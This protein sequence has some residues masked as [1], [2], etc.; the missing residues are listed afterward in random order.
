[1][2]I[3]GQENVKLF[4]TLP[5]HIII[6]MLLTYEMNATYICLHKD[7]YIYIYIYKIKEYIKLYCAIFERAIPISRVFRRN[8]L[9]LSIFRVPE[10]NAVSF[11]Q[12]TLNLTATGFQALG[13]YLGRLGVAQGILGEICGTTRGWIWCKPHVPPRYVRD[14]RFE[15]YLR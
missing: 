12:R 4:Y 14:L 6:H 1:M 15:K 2:G 9:L 7:L 11:R 13:G 3:I 10:G 5:A 8:V